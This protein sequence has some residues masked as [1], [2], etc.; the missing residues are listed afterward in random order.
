MFTVFAE[1]T[2]CSKKHV[3]K[4]LSLFLI[5]YAKCFSNS[6]TSCSIQKKEKK[7]VKNIFVV[8]VLIFK[9]SSSHLKIYF[10]SFSFFKLIENNPLFILKDNVKN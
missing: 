8:F 1:K 6:N 5:S 2:T 3:F 9:E 10:N 4:S 7:N